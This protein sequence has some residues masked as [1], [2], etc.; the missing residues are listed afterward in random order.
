MRW[1][2]Y[3]RG[4]IPGTT[5]LAFDRE[6]DLSSRFQITIN[7]NQWY[8]VVV[9]HENGGNDTLYVDGV[10]RNSTTAMTFGSDTSAQNY[11]GSNGPA[12][13]VW[14]GTIDEVKI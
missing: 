11:I 14:N 7:E 8:H 9:V 10:K 3:Y 2:F 5:G 1:Q 4:P 12:N 6:G 13:E